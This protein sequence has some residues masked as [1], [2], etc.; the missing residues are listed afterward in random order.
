[1]LGGR[2][3]EAAELVDVETK[4]GAVGR[5]QLVFELGVLDGFDVGR[6]WHDVDQKALAPIGTRRVRRSGNRTQVVEPTS[7]KKA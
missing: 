5:Y 2:S 7:E 3:A 4:I 1:M 6:T